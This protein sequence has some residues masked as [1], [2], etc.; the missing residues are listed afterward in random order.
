MP[1]L[2]Y[3]VISAEDLTRHPYTAAIGRSVLLNDNLDQAIDW[4]QPVHT[5]LMRR[6]I[7]LSSTMVIFLCLDGE[8]WLKQGA[9]EIVVHRNDAIFMR[10]GLLSEVKHF[11]HDV[12]FALI[13]M[14]ERF[15]FP[16]FNSLDIANLQTDLSTRSVCS[17]PEENMQ[18]CLTLYKMMKE[19]ILNRRSCS[20][21]HE[22]I[23]GYLQSITFIVY[24]NYVKREEREQK[25]AK[26]QSRQQ[27][28]YT[29]FMEELKENYAQERKIA[30]YADKICVTPRYLSRVIHDISGHFAGEHIDLFVIAEAKH[31]LRNGGYTILQ[32][33]EMLNFTS[34]SLFSRFFKKMAGCSP[35]EFQQMSTA[36][37]S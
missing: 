6:S 32:V 33:S 1:D 21:Q 29:Q 16:I 19:R 35:R 7:K 4:S 5:K 26:A 8:L 22:V 2:P 27:E 10:S 34:Q 24:A 9:Q 31:M 3:T 11:S 28:I 14:D 20:L 12:R 15:Y 37:A 36:T 30:W 18:E 13:I 23:R 25:R 17:L